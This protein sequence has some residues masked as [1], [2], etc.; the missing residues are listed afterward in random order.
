MQFNKRQPAVN[1]SFDEQSIFVLNELNRT[2]S[3][4]YES[5][6]K[7]ARDCI[8]DGLKVKNG[9]HKLVAVK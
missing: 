9:T 4:L 2:S 3:L 5:T 8:R 1:I 7:T 6:A